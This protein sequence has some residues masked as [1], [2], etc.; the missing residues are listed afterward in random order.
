METARAMAKSYDV[1]AIREDFPILKRKVHG[2]PLVYLDNAASAQRP[3]QVINAVTDFYRNYN[4]N[5]HR[6]V[7]QL[8]QEATE[9]YE[10]ARDTMAAYINANTRREVV[11]TRGT[12]ESVNLVAQSY[13]R[14]KLKPGD[15]ILITHME[16]HSNI[17]P[18]QILCEQ[19]G[20]VLTVAPINQRGEL[21]LDAFETLLSDKVKLLALTHISNALGTI[22]PVAELTR[23][24]K[25]LD[26]PVLIDGAQA[27]PHTAIDV[28]RIGCDFYCVS[29]H[30]MYGPTG[31]GILWARESLLKAMPPYQGG[32][33]MISYVSFDKTIYNEIPGKFEAGTP[34]IAGA[35]GMGAA[36]EYLAGIGL[37]RIAAYEHELL[38]YATEQLQ[39]I[40]GLKMIGTAGHK[41]GVAAFTIDGVHPNDLGTLIDHYG[42]AIRT[43]HHCAMPVM[44]F[45]GVPATSR[46][47][48]G[49]YNTHHEIDVLIEAVEKARRMLV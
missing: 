12:T 40:E 3:Q 18:W 5:I 2:K 11:F 45:F 27:A 34:N 10:S 19:T 37:D 49:I 29:G 30:K 1:D 9:S 47:S 8:S 24:A 21:E 35:I 16:H 23:K 14:P 46:A 36:A 4:S 41:A 7:H 22:N 33:E 28:Q 32:G 15:E 17:V 31:I 20:A 6:G 43:G 39:G 26:I 13:L 25:R 42:V 44:Q 38:E 48:L